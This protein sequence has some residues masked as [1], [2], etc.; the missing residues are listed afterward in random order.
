MI[1]ISQIKIL[2]NQPEELEIKVRK[3]LNINKNENIEI[4]I[5][6]ESIDARKKPDIFKVYTVDIKVSNESRFIK[7]TSK[8]QNISF[9]EE[10]NFSPIIK[11]ELKNR[12]VVCGFGPAGIFAAY[13]LALNGASPIVLERGE[14]VDDRKKAVSDFWNTGVL[15]NNSNVS[16][17]EGGAGTFSDGKLNTGVKDP[18]GYGEFVLNTLVKFGAD[19]SILYSSKPHVGTDKLQIIIPA[20]RKEIERLGGEIRFNQTLTNIDYKDGKLISVTVN[21]SDIIFCDKLILATGHSARDTFKMLYNKK[22]DMSAKAFAVGFRVEH[23][24]S[25]IDN[26][27]Y[28]KDR[29]EFLP[30]SPYKLSYT[31]KD[32][33]GIYSFCMCP[34]GYVVNSSSEKGG[35]CVNGMSYSGRDSENANSAIVVSVGLNDYDK[36]DALAGVRFQQKIESS[37]YKLCNGKIPQQLYGDF[38]QNKKSTSFGGINTCVKGEREFSNLR[39]ILSQDME[40][41]FILGMTEFGKKI[42]GFDHEEVILSGVEGRTSSPVRITRDESFQSNIKG[43]YPCGEGAG[44]AGGITS[45]AM[46]G[47]KVAMAILREE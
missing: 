38:V 32:N 26:V 11:K 4:V 43:V 10:S 20:I 18:F 42:R 39:G 29:D 28:G 23:P 35:L 31:P 36:D 44:Y 1:R 9:V 5:K 24:Q 46:D 27:M 3:L 16:F 12:P 45:A 40:N 37:A 25:L 19:S 21:D 17:G 2:Y 41:S 14:A 33:R 7:L 30:A 6:K 13:I 47:I 8:N 22:F 34:G 15:Y